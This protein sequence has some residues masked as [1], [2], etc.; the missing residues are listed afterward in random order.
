[1]NLRKLIRENI[2][3]IT[4]TDQLFKIDGFDFINKKID[5][6]NNTLWKYSKS[7]RS[8]HCH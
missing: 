8:G 1:M 4:G 7:I 6:N 2:E 3:S 5:A